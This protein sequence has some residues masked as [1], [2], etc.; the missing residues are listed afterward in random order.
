MA[1]KRK[2]VGMILSTSAQTNSVAQ[3]FA[4]SQRGVVG[5]TPSAATSSEA[6]GVFLYRTKLKGI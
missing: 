4:Y 5:R 1:S 3:R 2:E 6:S